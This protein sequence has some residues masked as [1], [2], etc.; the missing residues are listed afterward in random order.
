MLFYDIP[1][2]CN[3]EALLSSPLTRTPRTHRRKTIGESLR[4]ASLKSA[5][6]IMKQ[7][8]DMLHKQEN[9]NKNE[10]DTTTTTSSILTKTPQKRRSLALGK[11]F[12][13]SSRLENAM[14]VYCASPTTRKMAIV[15]N[16]IIPCKNRVLFDFILFYLQ[17][18]SSFK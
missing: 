18:I 1:R 12:G 11:R 10:E 3:F 15:W 9:N 7:H 5:E 14:Q 4:S 2:R 6:P 13:S 17:F 8:M 16:W